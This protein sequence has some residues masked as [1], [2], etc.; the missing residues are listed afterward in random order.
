MLSFFTAA[1]AAQKPVQAMIVTCH[2]MDI[3]MTYGQIYC[4]KSS[5]LRIVDPHFGPA[6]RHY[7][8]SLLAGWQNHCCRAEEVDSAHLAARE[9]SGH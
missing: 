3:P 5:S 6:S 2:G 4:T 7:G 1:L 8:L 9:V